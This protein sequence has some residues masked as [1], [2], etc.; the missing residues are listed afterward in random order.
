[1]SIE[2]P[3]GLTELLQGY[4]VEVLRHRPQDLL[5]FAVEYFCRLRDARDR[6]VRGGGGVLGLRAKGVNFDGEPMQ[7]ESNGEEERR[8]ANEDDEEDEDFE[9][10]WRCRG[11]GAGRLF[12][13]R[14]RCGLQESS[15]LASFPPGRLS[16]DWVRGAHALKSK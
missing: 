14:V 16:F 11:Q 3:S 5:D 15:A 9:R 7:T 1:M 13:S 12:S 6:D 8:E 2:I 4:T 10:E